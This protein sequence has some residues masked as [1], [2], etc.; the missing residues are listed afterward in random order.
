M[1]VLDLGVLN[2]ILDGGGKDVWSVFMKIKI[3]IYSN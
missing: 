2:W 1:I 3:I